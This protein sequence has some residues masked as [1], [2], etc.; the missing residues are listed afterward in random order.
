MSAGP[1]EGAPAGAGGVLDPRAARALARRSTWRALAWFLPEYAAWIGLAV[2]ALMPFPWP[3]SLAFSVLAGVAIGV[4][5][6]VGHDASHGALTPHRWL[7]QAIAR[8]AFV[9]SAHAAS[10]WDVGHNRIHHGSTNLLGAD[11]VWEPMTPEG[12]RRAGP[13]RRAL[14]RLYRSG[15]GHLPYYLVEMWWKKNF[16]PIAPETR[17][18]WRR[19]LPDSL[20]VIAAQ[21][22]LAWAAVRLGAALAPGRPWPVSLALGWLVPFLA[23]NWVMG[24]VIYMHHTHPAVGWFARR[25]EWSAR[26]VA[27]TGTVEARM[28]GALDRLDNNIMRHN[29]HHALP[30]IPMYNLAAA[31]EQ[32]RAGFP[33]ALSVVLGPGSVAASVRACKLWDPQARCW[34]R[35]D[36]R[37]SAPPVGPARMRAAAPG[38][39]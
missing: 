24:L 33:E 34:R 12:Y 2:L 36:G 22:L 4:V 26:A 3:L 31:Q 27:L 30:A 37:P 1:P 20:F 21:A 14:Y 7:N 8:L 25:E 18:E 6:T 5:F 28:P 32:L 13:L 35:F 29:A 15:A 39:P 19:H 11:Y 9:P 10:L 16:L 17:R 38:A 23:W